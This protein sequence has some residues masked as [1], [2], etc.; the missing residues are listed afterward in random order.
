MCIVGSEL[1]V[2]VTIVVLDNLSQHIFFYF[3]F[4][5][6]LDFFKSCSVSACSRALRLGFLV[7]VGLADVEVP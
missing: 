1:S 5:T 7:L 2:V 3:F 6:L 4:F